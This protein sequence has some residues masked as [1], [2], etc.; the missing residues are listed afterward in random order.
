MKKLCHL[1]IIAMFINFIGCAHNRESLPLTDYSR[2]PEKRLLNLVSQA[3]PRL[4]NT[5]G[6][7]GAGILISTD[8]I[9]MTDLHVTDIDEVVVI[10]FFKLSADDN[11]FIEKSFTTT[12]HVVFFSDPKLDFTLIKAK[13]L[14][15]GLTPL[16]LA[17]ADALKDDQPVWRFGYNQ[18]YRW[19]YGY[20]V[21]ATAEV[22]ADYVGKKMMISGGPGS[23]GGPIVNGRGQVLGIVQRG[24]DCTNT[25]VLDKGK[26][27]SMHNPAVAYFMS[28]DMIR[29][30]LLKAIQEKSLNFEGF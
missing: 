1:F 23:S 25:V 8:G 4:T 20:F 14:P 9:I 19:S 27:Y 15:P 24:Y 7:R 16:T 12:G 13:S 28:I 2:T 22:E 30:L 29:G 3:C 11:N 21:A 18:S 10:E 17:P 6:G 5:Q 26:R